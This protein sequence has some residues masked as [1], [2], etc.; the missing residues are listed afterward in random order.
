MP[1]TLLHASM[2]L[3]SFNPHNNLVRYLSTSI[4]EKTISQRG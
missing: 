4:G 3:I 1:G 2:G